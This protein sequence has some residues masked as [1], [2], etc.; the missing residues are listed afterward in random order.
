MLALHG[1]ESLLETMLNQQLDWEHAPLLWNVLHMGGVV[2]IGTIC[3][4]AVKRQ[5]ACQWQELRRAATL[6]LVIG[7]TI[8][9]AFQ[10]IGEIEILTGLDLHPDDDGSTS[11]IAAVLLGLPAIACGWL[12]WLVWK[13][14]ELRR[15]L[16]PGL[17]DALR[18]AELA[19]DSLMQFRRPLLRSPKVAVLEGQLRALVADVAGAS[20]SAAAAMHRASSEAE[21]V[22]DDARR[23]VSGQ[24]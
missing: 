8:A 21:S 16:K 1:T 9:L 6:G 12:G 14:L 4:S 7:I 23:D 22:I 13:Q 3:G 15:T 20:S 24:V 18:R 19:R 17:R 2:V 10:V 11:P 5:L